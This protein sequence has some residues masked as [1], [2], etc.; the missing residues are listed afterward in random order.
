[1]LCAG[2]PA[3]VPA[4]RGDLF[5]NCG[6]RTLVL[7]EY[8]LPY[9]GGE[10]YLRDTCEA[11]REMGHRVAVVCAKQWNG[12][13]IPSDRT[14]GVTPSVGLRT[15]LRAWGEYD[16][17]LRSE[18]PDLVFINGILRHFVSPVILRRLIRRHPSV[19]FVHHSGIFCHNAK[20]VTARGQRPC[21]WPLGHQC[22]RQGCVRALEGAAFQRL[23]MAF[24][25][26]WRA[27][28]LRR[29]QRV[30]APSQYVQRE[31]VRNGYSIERVRILPYFT[32]RCPG[33]PL[34]ATGRQILWVGR[35]DG[36]KGL[37]RFLRILGELSDREWR[38]VVVGDET[39][40]PEVR[41]LAEATG[42]ADR[43]CFRGRLEGE[44]LD[45]EYAGA[46][47]VVFTS[48]WAE[49]FGQVGIEAMA[50]GKPVIAFDVGGV[51]EWLS[52]G[53][54]GYVVP[55]DG[56]ARMRDRLS[57]LLAD[58]DLCA[59]M[60]AAGRAAVEARF[61]RHHHLPELLAVFREALSE[62]P[63]RGREGTGI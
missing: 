8:N 19:I 61:R 7:H 62:G 9:G 16:T 11:L 22:F 42:V 50:F 47:V 33:P 35:A 27:R 52:D 4:S 49:T 3:L 29:C 45:K 60:G 63:P 38:A 44:E 5:L 58:D 36:G 40:S 1:M 54:T 20:K 15:G 23:R 48:G 51:T 25:G 46:R 55:R 10:Q 14:Y 2:V 43:I 12:G 34:V 53:V 18:T 56:T 37:D 32:R 6:M 57:R 17:I 26:M 28:T 13:F 41:A 21:E 31:L 59:R 24:F 30:I 39:N